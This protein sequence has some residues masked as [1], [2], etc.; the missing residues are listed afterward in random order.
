[1]YEKIKENYCPRFV[2]LEKTST[3]S[4]PSLSHLGLSKRIIFSKQNYAHENK[5][6]ILF[7]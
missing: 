4:V 7:R 1:M 5:L 3:L 2:D 6:L